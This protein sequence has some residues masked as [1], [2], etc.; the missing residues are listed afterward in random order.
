MAGAEGAARALNTGRLREHIVT[1]ER[2]A[3]NS[4][5]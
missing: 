4:P 2:I 1:V 3:P 5:D